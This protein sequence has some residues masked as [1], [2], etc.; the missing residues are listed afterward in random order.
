MHG[1]VLLEAGERVVAAPAG[2]V[3]AGVDGLARVVH[4]LV[5]LEV[6]LA[7]EGPLA[8]ITGEGLGLRVDENV[9]FQLEF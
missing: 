7:P 3:G 6:V 9:T 5:V 1:L 2:L 8:R 4:L